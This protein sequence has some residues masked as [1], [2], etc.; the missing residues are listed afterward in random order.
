MVDPSEFMRVAG[1]QVVANR[2]VLERFMVRGLL[3]LGYERD[4]DHDPGA[5]ARYRPGNH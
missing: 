2:E 5:L 4:V 1:P 3:W